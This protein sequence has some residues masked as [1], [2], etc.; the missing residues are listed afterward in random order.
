M[1]L[2]LA[3]GVVTKRFRIKVTTSWFI[4][5]MEAPREWIRSFNVRNAHWSSQSFAIWET[6]FVFTMTKCHINADCA[7]NHS[8]K[9]ATEI[10]MRRRECAKREILLCKTRAQMNRI[11]QS[12]TKIARSSTL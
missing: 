12:L 11:K 5:L 4:G 9:Q 8:L 7:K 3:T 2:A 10:D 6:I 1:V